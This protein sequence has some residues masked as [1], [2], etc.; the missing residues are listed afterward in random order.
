MYNLEIYPELRAMVGP[1]AT[2]QAF[3]C[4]S[5]A[6]EDEQEALR[7]LF[8]AFVTANTDVVRAQVRTDDIFPGQ[9]W[10]RSYTLGPQDRC[11]CLRMLR[12]SRPPGGR[13]TSTFLSF[14]VPPFVG[15]V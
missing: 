10:R 7:A 12:R 14:H 4:T 5:G 2:A 15:R 8:R 13:G 6:R 9:P 3:A 1:E 11:C